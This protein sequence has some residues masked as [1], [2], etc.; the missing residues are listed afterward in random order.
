L[1]ELIKFNKHR[2]IEIQ[3]I[4]NDNIKKCNIVSKINKEKHK[5]IKDKVNEE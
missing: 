2:S 1:K 5:K 3:K 4:D